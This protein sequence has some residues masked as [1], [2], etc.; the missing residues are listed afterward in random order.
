MER[1]REKISSL[2]A[3]ID[4]AIERA[5]TAEQALKQMEIQQTERDQEVISYENRIKVLESE[6]QAR[7]GQLDEAKQFQRDSEATLNESD[8]L[9]K[10][11]STLEE[12]LDD[13]ENQLREALEKIRKYD[14]DNEGLQ[15]IITQH[16][17]DKEIM[18]QR[19]EDVSEKY[20]A[21]KNELEETIKML[22]SI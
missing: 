12:K 16:E 9:V 10:K 21:T 7:E 18:E 17:K 1:L 5:E 19:H 14:L 3:E 2:R 8:V 22:E 13:A 4:A 11:I 15:R 20:T 6:V